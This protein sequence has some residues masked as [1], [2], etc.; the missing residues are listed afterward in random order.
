MQRE[1]KAE[2][3]TVVLDLA[4]HCKILPRKNPMK[5]IIESNCSLMPSNCYF[6]LAVL[7]AYIKQTSYSGTSE[8][9]LILSLRVL[10]C[11]SP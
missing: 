8:Q 6:D 1:K 10:A 3:H 9:L 7:S 2:H 11:T 5:C 4:I